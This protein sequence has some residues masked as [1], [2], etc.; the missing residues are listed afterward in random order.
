MKPKINIVRFIVEGTNEQFFNYIPV[1]GGAKTKVNIH[2]TLYLDQNSRNMVK[3][4]KTHKIAL[5]MK[6]S[7]TGELQTYVNDLPIETLTQDDDFIDFSV[8]FMY[9]SDSDFSQLDLSLSYINHSDEKVSEDNVFFNTSIP[10]KKE[11]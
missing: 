7:D 2:F 3:Q 4:D 5:S 6:P 8:G 11:Q 10:V 1:I 9:Q